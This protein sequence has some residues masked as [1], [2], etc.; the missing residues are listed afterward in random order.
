M[1]AFRTFRLPSFFS[2]RKEKKNPIFI[3][4]FPKTTIWGTS[5]SI[6]FLSPVTKTTQS[7]PM[8]PLTGESGRDPQ[9][10]NHPRTRG[11][12]SKLEEDI[13]KEIAAQAGDTEDRALHENGRS[14]SC[15]R[16]LGLE[17]VGL[18]RAEEGLV[19][20][21]FGV[22]GGSMM[23]GEGR[24]LSSE[25]ILNS[26]SENQGNASKEQ[27]T[28]Q[29]VNFMVYCSL[30][31]VK[32]IKCGRIPACSFIFFFFLAGVHLFDLGVEGMFGEGRFS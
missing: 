29:Q 3:H 14:G 25:A 9:G 23:N 1:F 22:N 18:R 2:D 4:S 6:Q 8:E 13:H 10:K 26:R 28:S 11:V 5:D 30:L 21:G 12:D 17:V 20:N 31:F 7:N 24:S 16:S 19:A 15:S 27:S 32:I